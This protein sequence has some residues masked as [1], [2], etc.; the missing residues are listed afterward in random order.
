MRKS[1]IVLT[2]LM[3][4]CSNYQEVTWGNGVGWEQARNLSNAQIR[5]LADSVTRGHTQARSSEIAAG[6]NASVSGAKVASAAAPERQAIPRSG[7]HVVMPGENLSSIARRYDSGIEQLASLNQLNKPY[8]IYTGQEIWLK[9]RPAVPELYHVAGGDTFLGIAHRYGLRYDDMREQNPRV[10]P[11]SLLIGQTLYLAKSERAAPPERTQVARLEAAINADL[12]SRSVGG[13]LWPVSGDIVEDFGAKPSGI[14]NDGINIAA[15]LGTT[16]MAADAGVVVYAGEAL[17]AMGRMLMIRHADD[18]VT[19]YGHNQTLLVTVGDR[20]RQGQAIATVG[21]T[22]TVSRAQ[23]HFQIRKGK[24][25]V[26]PTGLLQA[27]GTRLAS[28]G[29]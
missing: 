15:A 27:A 6:S 19:A 8:V 23:L 21:N 22:G 29:G 9:A 5:Q 26:N 18:F 10:D 14:R 11:E 17:P 7:R 28:N 2:V 13:F 4:G 16:V 25:P 3:A 20:V 1:I 24:D 12:P